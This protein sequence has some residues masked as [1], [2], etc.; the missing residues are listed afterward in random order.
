MMKTLKTF[1]L[2][3]SLVGT[4]AF[5]QS[6]ELKCPEGTEL[7]NS[8]GVVLYCVK[9]GQ[10]RID[11]TP[12]VMLHKNG[13]VYAQGEF[14][15]SKREGRWE[16]FDEEG[17]RTGVSHFKDDKFEGK[18]TFYDAE[19]HVREEQNWQDGKREGEQLRFEK[20]ER[21]IRQYKADRLVTP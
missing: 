7:F 4:A 10:R 6:V 20:G 8:E 11:T 2:A 5:A 1:I 16:Y 12:Y 14:V 19:G 3:S 9:P 15:D 18:R 13:K 21:R 17:R